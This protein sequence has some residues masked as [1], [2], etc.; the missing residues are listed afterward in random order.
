MVKATPCVASRNSLACSGE[1]SCQPAVVQA[2]AC[3]AGGVRQQGLPGGVLCSTRLHLPAARQFWLSQQHPGQHHAFCPS[4][5]LSTF[6]LALRIRLLSVRSVACE[7]DSIVTKR[8]QFTTLAQQP[9]PQSA[10]GPQPTT[11]THCSTGDAHLSAK[12]ILPTPRCRL[13]F[14]DPRQPSPLA[15]IRA[16]LSPMPLTCG[17]VAHA[18]CRPPPPPRPRLLPPPLHPP[19]PP[20]QPLPRPRPA[21]APP[22]GSALPGSPGECSLPGG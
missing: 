18:C 1:G 13:R 7:Q 2:L 22:G 20:R 6:C 11:S 17:G 21:A 16:A 5:C 9:R 19:L 12:H 4:S 8:N 10:Q 14:R 3:W 15:A